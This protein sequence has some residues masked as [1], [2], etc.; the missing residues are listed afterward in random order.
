MN[1]WKKLAFVVALVAGIC[2]GAWAAQSEHR[3]KDK[4]PG[5]GE[6]NPVYQ[7]G[8]NEGLKSGR[9]DLS[10]N[11]AYQPGNYKAYKKGDEV[12]RSGFMAGYDKGFGRGES[13]ESQ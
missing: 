9:Y 12:Y 13:Q 11:R 1:Y 7:T 10:N 3:D 4:A 8:Y 2:G 5:Y 6:A